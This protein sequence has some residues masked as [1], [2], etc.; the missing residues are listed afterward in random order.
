MV[1]LIPKYVVRFMT[2][3]VDIN[4]CLRS[5][6]YLLDI[7]QSVEQ[8]NGRAFKIMVI[9]VIHLFVA[10][11]KYMKSLITCQSCNNREHHDNDQVGN[12]EIGNMPHFH[13][14]LLKRSLQTGFAI[15][16]AAALPL[17][18]SAI[19]SLYVGFHVS[20]IL[21]EEYWRNIVKLTI[22]CLFLGLY[23]LEYYKIDFPRCTAGMVLSVVYQ[24]SLFEK[25][26]HLNNLKFLLRSEI[27]F[28]SFMWFIIYFVGCT[29]QNIVARYRLFPRNSGLIVIQSV[30]ASFVINYALCMIVRYNIAPLCIDIKH[31]MMESIV[32]A[33]APFLP[34][35]VSTI[36]CTYHALKNTS[37]ITNPERSFVFVCLSRGI[38]IMFYNI[39]LA[40]FTSIWHFIGI[41]MLRGF[42]KVAG[43]ATEKLRSKTWTYIFNAE[44]LEDQQYNIH[45]HR[46]F[47]ADMAI[48]DMLLDCTTTILSQAFV[49]LWRTT[50]CEISFEDVLNKALV[51]IAVRL[52]IDF[53]FS[54]VHIFVLVRWYDIPVCIVWSRYWKY[55]MLVNVI[56]VLVISCMYIPLIEAYQIQRP[57]DGEYKNCTIGSYKLGI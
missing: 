37:R 9:M 1:R 11:F 46:R 12:E 53:F 17:G 28:D 51:R 43:K 57:L 32:I 50:H 35:F 31:K 40:D 29:A 56:A 54:C 24:A 8:T 5:V 14:S 38:Y 36:T 23:C 10:V 26:L 13:R 7:T 6:I 42:L 41:C 20:L 34:E 18:I 33:I 16:V 2:R 27:P 47:M 45:D 22:E 4:N 55:H 30:S 52:A 3:C 39:L 48:Q 25:I 44:A 49:A 21:M 19:V 15:K